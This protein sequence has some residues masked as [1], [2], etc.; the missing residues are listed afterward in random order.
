MDW[1]DAHA[2]G[3][4]AVATLVLV[5]LTGYYAWT[6]QAL[7]RESRITLRATA[8]MA[9]QTRLDRLSEV[10]IHEPALYL[11]LDQL[12]VAGEEQDARFHIA[13]MF[14]SVLEEAHTQYV[15]ERSM[16][17]ADWDAWIATCD[18]FLHRRYVADYWQRVRT[19]YNAS[20]QTFVEERLQ[21]PRA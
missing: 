12:P 14:V 15:H 7:V 13:N 19:T 1:L 17:R 2:G 16:T 11:S 20:F 10:L 6:S 9:P 21:L 8:R 18:Y 3:V 5:M 4:Q